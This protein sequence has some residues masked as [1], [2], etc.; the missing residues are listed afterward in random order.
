[1][2]TVS[3]D[4]LLDAMRFLWE[5]MKLVV[6]P[7][8]ALGLAARL[9]RARATSAGKRVGVILSGGNVDLPAVAPLLAKGSSGEVGGTEGPKAGARATDQP[10]AL[11][12]AAEAFD[13]W[14]GDR[15]EERKG[16]MSTRSP[17]PTPRTS[18]R[19]TSMGPMPACCRA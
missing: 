12:A 4:E 11:A 8:G 19:P 3:D 1:M 2:V 9:A 17:L 14:Q 18:E 10:R 6:E 7:T 16:V 15:L 13:L 5:R